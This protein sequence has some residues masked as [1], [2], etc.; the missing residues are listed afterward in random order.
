VVAFGYSG[1]CVS[2]IGN[3]GGAVCESGTPGNYFCGC[4]SFSDCLPDY[5]C[6]GASACQK[7]C[8]GGL[9]CNA[10]CCDGASC[11]G[12][13]DSAT[14]GSDGGACVS[15][16]NALAGD[17]CIAGMPSFCGCN[18]A[19]DCPAQLACNFKNNQ[20]DQKCGDPLHSA[21]NGGCCNKNMCAAGNDP[22]ACGS[23]NACVDC[24]AAPLGHACIGG[25][26]G[27]NSALDCGPNADCAKNQLCC[28][29]A[30]ANCLVVNGAPC[31]SGLCALGRCL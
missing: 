14:C 24:S 28:S 11:V 13:G 27:C 7:S 4:N 17:V 30:G 5:A 10:G 9:R 26:C 1:T 19:P 2:C 31:C 12:G 25:A 20:C 16:V 21:C 29:K 8:A 6:G 15:C 23:G 22:K 18:A 3:A